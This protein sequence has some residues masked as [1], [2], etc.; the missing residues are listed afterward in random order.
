MQN[1]LSCYLKL[2]YANIECIVEV[3]ASMKVCD[4]INIC[5]IQFEGDIK[6]MYL[7]EAKTNRIL[8]DEMSFEENQIRSGDYLYFI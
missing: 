1:M 8:C 5:H 4:F 3:P 7:F 6:G 2:I